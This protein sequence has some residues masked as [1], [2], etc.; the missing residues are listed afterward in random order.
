MSNNQTNYLAVDIAIILYAT[1]LGLVYYVIYQVS[2]EA[3]Y[4]ALRR[5]EVRL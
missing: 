5:R 1:A 4:E 3:Y 2:K